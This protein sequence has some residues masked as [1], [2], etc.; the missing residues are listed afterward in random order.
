[1]EAETNKQLQALIGVEGVPLLLKL[2]PGVCHQIS[3]TKIAN[4]V[5]SVG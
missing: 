4:W 5:S 2:P 3:L 1:M